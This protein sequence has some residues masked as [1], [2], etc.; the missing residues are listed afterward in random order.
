MNIKFQGEL[1][2]LQNDI[3]SKE[4]TYNNVLDVKILLTLGQYFDRFNT[5]GYGRK[6]CKL[7]SRNTLSLF[8]VL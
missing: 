8:T 1:Q 3:V 2:F 7:A 5:C 4:N 6:I